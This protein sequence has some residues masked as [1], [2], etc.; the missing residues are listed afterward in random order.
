MKEFNTSR[1][2][3]IWTN[4]IIT[5]NQ[6]VCFEK[7]VTVNV[8]KNYI[9]QVAA[10]SK[11]WLYIN[12]VPVV[13]EGNLN[14]GPLPGAGYIDEIDV[15]KH[16]K[17]GENEIKILVWYWGN[18]GRNNISCGQP[19]LLFHSDDLELYSDCSWI[20]TRDLRYCETSDPQPSFLF[21]GFNIGY[22]ATMD[23]SEKGK[24]TKAIEY[25]LPPNQPWGPLYKRPI[26]LFSFSG[27]KDYE[28][29]N[30]IHNQIIADLPYAMHISPF[31]E[32]VAKGGEKIDIRTDRYEVNGGPGEENKTYRGL[33]TE[34]ICKPGLNRFENL[35]GYYG[36]SVIY[37]FSDDVKTIQLGYRA[38]SYDSRIVGSLKVDNIDVN[39]LIEKSMRTLQVCMRDNF[40]DCPDREKGQWIGDVSVQVP[41]VFYTMERTSDALILKAITDFIYHRK[42]NRLVGNVPGRDFIELPAQSLNAISEFGMIAAYYE[43]YKELDVL[44]LVFDPIIQYLKLW[45]MNNEG[46]VRRLGDWDWYDHLA[47]VDKEVLEYTWYYSAL[48]FALRISGLLNDSRYE[49][50]INTRIHL[51][52]HNFKRYW[53]GTHYSSGTF[54]DERAN[55][56]AVLVGLANEA[57]YPIILDILSH[58]KQASP[59]M[60]NY[61]LEALC[62]MGYKQAAH[63]RALERYQSLIH[64]S[65]STLWENFDSL[66]T[67][68]H[69]WS[70]GPLTMYFKHF[71]GIRVTK[72]SLSFTPNLT[73][74]S[75]MAAIIPLIQG[76]LQIKI[77]KQVNIEIVIS[78]PSDELKINLEAGSLG[79]SKIECI[80]L[81]GVKS[82]HTTMVLPKG[83]YKLSV[84][85]N[86]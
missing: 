28:R 82:N 16:L 42:G 13:F 55:A 3:W 31:F 71:L 70:G 52:K 22:V 84:E 43:Y 21:G 10:D 6:W 5:Q 69:A 7:I 68:N 51:I 59:Y 37:T 86:E 2:K 11:Y 56:M 27:I 23:I 85:T 20:A 58:T 54:V 36:E 57:E 67:R 76:D 64:N 78:N 83:T 12:Q 74:F 35:Y 46:L 63:E 60:E 80:T 49:N 77:E 32:V 14:R 26:P 53:K 1:A 38:V 8:E 65:N 73:V 61:I 15:S 24:D 4:D 25:G 30:F 44:K 18:E 19:G 29:E 75:S 9:I 39:K 45:E 79:V 34:Y 66:G 50:F 48:K 81:N 33:R 72:D 41:Q 62:V 40:M 17:I 47:N